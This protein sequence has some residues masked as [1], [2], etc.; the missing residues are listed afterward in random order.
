MEETPFWEDIPRYLILTEACEDAYGLWEPM[1]ELSLAFPDRTYDDLRRLVTE[2]L[3]EFLDKN[4]IELA[5]E[6]T[7]ATGI[8]DKRGRDVLEWNHQVVP[9]QEAEV[10][11][12]NDGNW[13]RKWPEVVPELRFFCTLKGQKEWFRGPGPYMGPGRI[14]LSP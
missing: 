7:V 6:T 10:L 5:W 12:G 2:V 11:L 13:A 1:G 3:L 9:Q 4:W 8:K 14:P